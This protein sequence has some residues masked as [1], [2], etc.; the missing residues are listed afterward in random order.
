MKNRFVLAGVLALFCVCGYNA[1]TDGMYTYIKKH[2]PLPKAKTLDKLGEVKGKYRKKKRKKNTGKG[3]LNDASRGTNANPGNNFNQFPGEANTHDENRYDRNFI[4]T[5]T[6]QASSKERHDSEEQGNEN[7]EDL[8]LNH[9]N[10][11]LN[12]ENESLSLKANYDCDNDNY[13]DL[14]QN[15]S[16][17]QNAIKVIPGE[18]VIPGENEEDQADC[19]DNDDES[20]L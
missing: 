16:I 11:F 14:P 9:K 12:P 1:T 3:S 19:E 8:E 7:D 2:K 10:S 20:N 13:D 4:G 5:K 15:E 18:R 17:E 6:C